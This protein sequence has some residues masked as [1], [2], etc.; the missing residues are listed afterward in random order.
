VGNLEALINWKWEIKQNFF[1]EVILPS[2]C[3]TI[4]KPHTEVEKNH[5]IEMGITVSHINDIQPAD[6]ESN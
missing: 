1:V 3:S 4:A 2:I 5:V 6:Y